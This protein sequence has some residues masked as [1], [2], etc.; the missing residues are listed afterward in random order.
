MR[1]K[2][3]Y[4][5]YLNS[6]L[7]RTYQSLGK[8]NSCLLRERGSDKLNARRGNFVNARPPV[9]QAARTLRFAA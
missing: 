3:V 8:A 7:F 1:P 5:V 6:K 9:F 2:L 4:D